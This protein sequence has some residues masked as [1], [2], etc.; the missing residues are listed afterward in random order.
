MFTNFKFSMFKQG[1]KKYLVS[2]SREFTGIYVNMV[3]QYKI[4]SWQNQLKLFCCLANLS[5]V[6]RNGGCKYPYNCCARSAN[7][8]PN[9]FGVLLAAALPVKAPSQAMGDYYTLFIPFSLTTTN[10][11]WVPV[12]IYIC[13]KL[14]KYKSLCK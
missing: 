6:L 2:Q 13:S 12:F 9:I 14:I 10:T 1:H 4:L 11:I 8:D 5:I 3:I 7:R